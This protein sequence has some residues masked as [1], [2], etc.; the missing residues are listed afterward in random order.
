MLT[1]S[2][3]RDFASE[4]LDSFRIVIPSWGFANT[5]ARFGTFVQAAATST[6][7][8]EFAAEVNRLSGVTPSVAPLVLWDLPGRQRGA[9]DKLK[10]Q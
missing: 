10:D 5:G 6:I 3:N 9:T 4:A 1:D 7:G 8:E 2:N